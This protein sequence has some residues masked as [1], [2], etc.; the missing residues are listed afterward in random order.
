MLETCPQ[1]GNCDF[2]DGNLCQ[3]TSSQDNAT[4]SWSINA[5]MTLTTSINTFHPIR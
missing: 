3:W 2:E 1:Y 4:F 5:K